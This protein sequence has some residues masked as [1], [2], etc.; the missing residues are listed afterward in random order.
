MR[1]RRLTV[2]C[3]A[4]VALGLGLAAC[5]EPRYQNRTLSSWMHD[6]GADEDYK[7]RAAC[8]AIGELGPQ[9]EKAIPE[10][11]GLMDDVNEGIRDFAATALAKVGPTAKPAL[12]EV[13]ARPEPD[14]RLYAASALIQLDPKHPQAGEVLVKAVTGVG[15][16]ELAQRAQEIVIRGGEVLVP[17]LTPYIKDPYAPVRLQV[18]KTLGKMREKAQGAVPAVKDAIGD[19][20]IEVR[21]QALTTLAA[22][23]TR[24]QVEG[25]L[26]G[27]L[28]DQVEEVATTAAMMLKYI[29]A[30]TSASGNETEAPKKARKK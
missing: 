6:L 1:E 22:I 9:A 12:E 2:A 7:R 5:N 4:T 21:T 19:K 24:D 28:D 25:T 3:I 18:L 13:L 26:R 17:I 20:E 10:L 30:R 8:E 16:A 14:V 27:H 23:G 11:V 15:N 29:G